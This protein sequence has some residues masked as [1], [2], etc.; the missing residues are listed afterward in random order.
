MGNQRN[1]DNSVR[2][3][4]NVPDNIIT[5]HKHY[6]ACNRKWTSRAHRFALEGINIKNPTEKHVQSANE[7]FQIASVSD[8]LWV[9]YQ[10][11]LRGEY[12][13]VQA[14]RPA[15]VCNI[16]KTVHLLTYITGQ[17]YFRFRFSCRRK[18]G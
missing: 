1:N 2:K 11:M 16:S 3:K 8:I 14:N 5:L 13:Q 7:L 12:L 15:F 6:L 17:R 4:R 18:L 9:K 10:L